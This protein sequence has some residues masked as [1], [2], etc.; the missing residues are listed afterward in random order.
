MDL[1]HGKNCLEKYTQHPF[2]LE[3][4]TAEVNEEISE[5]QNKS[6]VG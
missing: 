4:D 6:V 3:L 2:P 1:A 5:D